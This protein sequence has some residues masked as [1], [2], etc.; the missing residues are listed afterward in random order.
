MTLPLDGQGRVRIPRLAALGGS[1]KLYTWLRS[2]VVGKATLSALLLCPGP[3]PP[4]SVEVVFEEPLD[5][6]WEE[7]GSRLGGSRLGGRQLGA[8]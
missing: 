4:T 5:Y 6:R 2:S 8:G 3:Q 7:V 1:C